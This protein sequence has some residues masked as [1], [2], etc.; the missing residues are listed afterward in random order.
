MPES[1]EMF[2]AGGGRPSDRR[3]APSLVSAGT[4]GQGWEPV[5]AAPLVPVR[6]RTRRALYC[7][8]YGFRMPSRGLGGDATILC[9]NAMKPPC[10]TSAT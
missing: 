9:P 1:L 5:E 7:T 4:G 6:R 3:R 10:E 2:R 8:A